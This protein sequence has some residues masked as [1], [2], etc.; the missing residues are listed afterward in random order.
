FIKMPTYSGT[1]LGMTGAPSVTIGTTTVGV[2]S[3]QLST[4]Y[5]STA[6]DPASTADWSTTYT[7]SA[8]YVAVEI[9]QTSGSSPILNSET[10]QS[11][12]A[13]SVST[14]QI[15]VAITTNQPTACGASVTNIANSLSDGI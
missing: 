8:T 1:L 9:G 14:A 6:A 2:V 11:S 3:G 4:V 5:Y 13:G 15:T 7:A 12:G 10:G